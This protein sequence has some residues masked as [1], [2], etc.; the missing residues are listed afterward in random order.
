VLPEAL[1]AHVVV[2]PDVLQD[3]NVKHKLVMK[4]QADNMALHVEQD[5]V[6]PEVGVQH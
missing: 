6:N 4:A 1:V 2:L 5:T 3:I